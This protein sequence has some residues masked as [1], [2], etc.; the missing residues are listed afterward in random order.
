[1]RDMCSSEVPVVSATGRDLYHHLQHQI[2]SNS[3]IFDI[4]EGGGEAQ[5]GFYLLFRGCS[6]LCLLSS[7]HSWISITICI[8]D[9]TTFLFTV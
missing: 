4:R 9:V 6:T 1:M 2:S 7:Q 8:K 3:S 5:S